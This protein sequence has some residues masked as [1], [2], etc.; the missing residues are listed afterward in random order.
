MNARTWRAATRPPARL[1]SRGAFLSALPASP[2]P[3]LWAPCP[4]RKSRA[5]TPWPASSRR[6]STRG[7]SLGG[8]GWPS[9]GGRGGVGGVESGSGDGATPH[10]HHV[11]A[12]GARPV[13][14]EERAEKNAA[15][16]RCRRQFSVPPTTVAAAVARRRAR[17]LD[18]RAATRPIKATERKPKKKSGRLQDSTAFNPLS[19]APP[20]GRGARCGRRGGRCATAGAVAARGQ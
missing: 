18:T 9:R 3:S 8:R 4:L 15:A 12:C 20:P 19:P 17:A 14:E 5:S 13:E 2:P 10:H 7:R 1:S 6:R 11:C 16:A